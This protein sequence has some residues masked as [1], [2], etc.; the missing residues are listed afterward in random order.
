MIILNIHKSNLDLQLL[1][2][3]RPYETKCKQ[4][5][6]GLV[7]IINL[8]EG[9]VRT[10]I[11]SRGNQ[12]GRAPL[13]ASH[14]CQR[15]EAAL[16]AA[17]FLTLSGAITFTMYAECRNVYK[18]CQGFITLIETQ[19]ARRE[20][21]KETFTNTEPFQKY[22]YRALVSMQ[23]QLNVP[24]EWVNNTFWC[25][26]EIYIVWVTS[27]CHDLQ[28]GRHNCPRMGKEYFKSRPYQDSD[29]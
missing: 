16:S 13:Y 26:L 23:S 3:K 24:S 8:D 14:V 2:Q 17:S 15:A 6:K 20:Q 22:N 12:R 10:D 28:Q 9:E 11:T 18:T 5:M 1:Y 27:W 21:I 29:P 19:F 4:K 25:Q 7:N